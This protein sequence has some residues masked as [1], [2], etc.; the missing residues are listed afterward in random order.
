MENIKK[1]GQNWLLELKLEYEKK[2]NE[3]YKKAQKALS[4]H[5]KSHHLLILQT[6]LEN[7]M[8][9]N[10]FNIQTSHWNVLWSLLAGL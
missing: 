7:E 5:L 1:L 2:N 10:A 6:N 3:K 8:K 4:I 9:L